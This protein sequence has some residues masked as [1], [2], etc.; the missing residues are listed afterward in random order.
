MTFFQNFDGR[1]GEL[2]TASP[3]Y[4]RAKATVQA[5]KTMKLMLNKFQS[6]KRLTS[7]PTAESPKSIREAAIYLKYPSF[8]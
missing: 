1:I 6:F 7:T 2:F 3:V 5:I 4:A 8:V